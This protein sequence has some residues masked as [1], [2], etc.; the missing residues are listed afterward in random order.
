MRER[1]VEHGQ[2]RFHMGCFGSTGIVSGFPRFPYVY[3]PR[4]PLR[5]Y[6]GFGEGDIWKVR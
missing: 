3:H 6:R 1:D 4:V 5:I 2:A